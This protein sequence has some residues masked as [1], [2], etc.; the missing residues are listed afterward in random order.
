MKTPKENKQD[1]FSKE[2]LL[3]TAISRENKRHEEFIEKILV[4]RGFHQLPPPEKGKDY[5]TDAEIKEIIEEVYEKIVI[6]EVEIDYKI[7]EEY[8]V[9]AVST[10]VAK[11]KPP[12]GDKGDK[13]DSI[14]GEPGKDAVVNIDDIIK[15]VIKGLPKST[16]QKPV[17][18]KEVKDYIDQ[19]IREINE[20]PVRVVPGASSFAMLTDVIK[21][22]IPQDEHGN[23]ILTPGGGGGGHTIQEE[24]TPLAQRTKL[25]FKG[26]NIT[27]TDNAGDDSTD[28]TVDVSDK[29]DDD[30]VVHKTGTETIEGTKTYTSRVFAED[31][32]EVVTASNG[33]LL[34]GLLFSYPVM[35]L[36]NSASDPD[37]GFGFIPA[38]L[39]SFFGIPGAAMVSSNGTDG[40]DA[41]MYRTGGGAWEVSNMATGALGTINMLY[42]RFGGDSPEGVVTAPVGATYRDT[43]NGLLYIKRTGTGNTGWG[44]SADKPSPTDGQ[45]YAQKNG[46]YVPYDDKYIFNGVDMY[47]T[48]PNYSTLGDPTKYRTITYEADSGGA[49]VIDDSA[50]PI[51]E[52]GRVGSNYHGGNLYNLSIVDGSPIQN[53]SV[54]MG[55]S[56]RYATLTTEIALTADFSIEF[57]IIKQE[58]SAGNAFQ[59]LLSS[60][61]SSLLTLY[62]Y[63]KGHAS[64][65][66]VVTLVGSTGQSTFG[67]VGIFADVANGQHC[68]VK[69]TRVSGTTK[70]YVD[71]VEKASVAATYGT[72]KI[73]TLLIN[74]NRSTRPFVAGS[75]MQDLQISDGTNT[76]LYALDEGTGTQIVNSGTTGVPYYGAWTTATWTVLPPNSRFY[77]IRDGDGATL[78]ELNSAE[79]A[80]IQN[81]KRKNWKNVPLKT[82]IHSKPAGEPILLVFTG[83]SNALGSI[84]RNPY[85]QN[86]AV[87][88]LSTQGVSTPQNL[89]NLDW[90]LPVQDTGT[91]K[92]DVDVTLPY[93]GYT[94]A[95][96]GNIALAC[97]NDLQI[98]TGR[99]VYVVQS[100]RAGWSIT[101][102]ASPSGAMFTSLNDAVDFALATPELAGLTGPDAVIWMQGETDAAAAMTD[103]AYSTAWR[104]WRTAIEALWSEPNKTQYFICEMTEA[105]N[106]I[107]STAF[108]PALDWD[109]LDQTVDD[110]DGFVSL[111]S[112]AGLPAK[113]GN[114]I[115]YT[116]NANNALGERVANK[117][118]YGEF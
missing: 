73:D 103:A 13:G 83:Q 18:L 30:A 6:P 2:R 107:G 105:Y 17:S 97:A 54:V 90:A 114:E 104:A 25:N 39:M 61:A 7:L 16:A 89:A 102:W 38:G 60:N 47:S 108:G 21:T 43:T 101:N 40:L 3:L 111:V 4:E 99:D 51:D 78:T 55:N 23:Y 93:V 64:F 91:V 48:M 95:K 29:A 9:R 31:G 52:F 68:K 59:T 1:P 66:D 113:V 77:S 87:W 98:A 116:G 82:Q 72:V 69:I 112:S 44:L 45:T 24:G 96:R 118:L 85:T 67:L 84:A 32:I 92:G 106:R 27:A 81:Y 53:S 33:K 86:P 8:I 56:S 71:D 26:A 75:A 109:G 42:D 14:K 41:A 115:H 74:N 28:V 15:K 11:L 63:D 110:S 62:V 76:Y 79:D 88:D 19:N 10:Y 37:P 58:S 46:L 22:G 57:N 100:C 12:K 80:T 35:A 50:E 94:N 34:T 65:P 117:I 70:I 36:F 5:L 20:R 49:N